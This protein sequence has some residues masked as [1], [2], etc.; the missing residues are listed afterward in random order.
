[1]GRELRV[2]RHTSVILHHVCSKLQIEII[3]NKMYSRLLCF[4]IS[5]TIYLLYHCYLCRLQVIMI[6]LTLNQE[7]ILKFA[8]KFNFCCENDLKNLMLIISIF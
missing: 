2:S 1:M 3:L 6:S 5:C 8:N 4:H 7:A